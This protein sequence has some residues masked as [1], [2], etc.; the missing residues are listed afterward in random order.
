MRMTSFLRIQALPLLGLCLAAPLASASD[1]I[2]VEAGRT[3]RV[4]ALR[5]RDQL[6]TDRASVVGVLFN[7][8]QRPAFWDEPYAEVRRST[9]VDRS[10]TRIRQGVNQT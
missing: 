10:P 4:E 1:S 7:H 8:T 9:S 3:P 5:A 6:R 2:V